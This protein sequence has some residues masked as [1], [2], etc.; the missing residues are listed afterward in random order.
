MYRS[1]NVFGEE[2]HV[3]ASIEAGATGYIL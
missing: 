3:L 2:A 1:V